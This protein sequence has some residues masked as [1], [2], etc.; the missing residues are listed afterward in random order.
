MPAKT[1]RRAARKPRVRSP[2]APAAFIAPMAAT[3]VRVLPDGPDWSYELKFDGYRALIVKNGSKVSIRSRNDKDLCKL[4]PSLPAAAKRIDAKQ[5]VIDGEIVAIDENGKPSFQMLQR[6]GSIEPRN[7]RY[8]AFDLLH[9]DGADLKGRALMERRERL[10]ALIDGS[11]LLLSEELRGTARDVVAT[12]EQLGLEGAVAKRRD[13]F[14]IPG[15]RTTDWQKLK[16]ELAQ[17]FVIGGYRPDAD[18]VDALLVG[19]YEGGKLKFGGKVRAGFVPHTRREVFKTLQPLH[20][21][22]C[23]FADLPTGPKSSRWGGGI[24][25]DEMSDMVWLE[26]KLLAQIR[27][28]EWTGDGRLR[29]A[30]FLGLRDDKDPQEVRREG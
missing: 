16:L 9:V 29:L 10:P 22:H 27:F 8:Y 6:R 13:S 30:K 4:Y 19:Y 21:R 5:A 25:A 23:P 20:T 14:Y 3:Q 24:T 1:P 18:S 7:I 26:P 15:E 12:I 11:G 17:E 28:A 2:I